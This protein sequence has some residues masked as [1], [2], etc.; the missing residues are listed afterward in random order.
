MQFG[1][2]RKTISWII[3]FSCLLLIV[4]TRVADETGYFHETLEITGYLLLSFASL[5]RIWSAIY[6]SG[7][8]NDELCKDGPYSIMRNPLYIFSFIGVVG[9]CWGAKN[10]L[11]SVL[12]SVIFILYYHFVIKSEE[13]R[14]RKIFGEEYVGYCMK[15]PKF[16]PKIKNFFS[17]ERIEVN[18][19]L[20]FRNVIEAMCF[21]W[22]F[23]FLEIVEVL[24]GI[25]INGHLLIP[26]LYNF[27][28]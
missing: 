9:A 22:F 11:L 21:V 23:F 6:I 25:K 1:R 12:L 2:Y 28:F 15:V 7:R 24:K 18:P 17:R 5:G 16:C 20:L 4:F 27:R 14:L 8:K 13:R 26:S 19:G 10:L 3:A